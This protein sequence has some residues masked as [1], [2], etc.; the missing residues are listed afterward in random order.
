MCLYSSP[1]MASSQGY[2]SA[3]LHLDTVVVLWLFN[4]VYTGITGYYTGIT[5]NVLFIN[6]YPSVFYLTLS[7]LILQNQKLVNG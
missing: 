4:C 3:L 5:F 7:K 6:G 1:V 2:I